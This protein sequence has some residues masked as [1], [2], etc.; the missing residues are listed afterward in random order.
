MTALLIAIG[1][2]LLGLGK[3]VSGVRPSRQL[4]RLRHGQSRSVYRTAVPRCSLGREQIG[5]QLR[6]ASTIMKRAQVR[7]DSADITTSN[8]DMET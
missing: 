3:G 8:D 6:P 4:R 5:V 7:A 1:R 2:P